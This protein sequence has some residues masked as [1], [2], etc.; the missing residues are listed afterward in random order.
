MKIEDRKLIADRLRGL[1]REVRRASV[2][3]MELREAPDGALTLT[4]YA[5]VTDTPYDM[6]AYQETIK[7]GAFGKTLSE[8]PDVQLLLNHEGLPL[9]RTLSGTLSLSEDDRGLAVVASLNP[10]DPDV[11]RLAPKVQRGDIDQMSFA[12]RVT[13]Q[14]WDENYENRD[15]AEV[16]INRGDVSIVNQGANPATSFSM[17]DARSFLSG[18]SRDEFVALM[19]SIAPDVLPEPPEVREE[20]KPVAAGYP[21]DL[22][23]R[24]ALALR[25]RL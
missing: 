14:N 6:G 13:R 8:A 12:F 15:I 25:T 20:A 22:A 2:P 11:Q 18:L 21:L 3:E 7:R 16:N 24:R 1:A 10:N 19:R 4:G 17:R 5:S 9:A 23:R